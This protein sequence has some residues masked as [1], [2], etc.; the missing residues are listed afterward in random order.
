MSEPAGAAPQIRAARLY[1]VP[2]LLGAAAVGGSIPAEVRALIC[3]LDSFVAESAKSAR[4]F[5]KAVGHPGPLSAVQIGELNEHTPPSALPDLLA[6]AKAGRPLGLLSEAGCPG[7]ADP[8]ASLVALAHA[9]AVQVVPL[10]GPCSLLLALMASGLNGQRFCFQGY[11]AVE[12]TGREAAIRRVEAE[13]R[14]DGSA[15][16]FIEA[17]YR[18]QR[19]LQALLEVC[20]DDT[21]LCLATDLTLSSQAISTRTV[22]NWRQDV[23]DLDRRPTVFILQAA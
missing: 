13:S 8:G 19:L 18:N 1:L 21:R 6:P 15:Q 10:V 7:V 20:R 4:R 17:P 5:L 9:Q 22:A 12:R 23:P 16:L 11:L 2:T 14:R 3:A